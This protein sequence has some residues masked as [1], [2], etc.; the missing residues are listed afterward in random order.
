MEDKVY[1]NG[2]L[3]NF[4]TMKTVGSITIDGNVYTLCVSRQNSYFIRFAGNVNGATEMDYVSARKWADENL[5]K[6]EYNA[7]FG[8]G[9]DNEWR[10]IG[11]ISGKNLE[12]L[13]RIRGNSDTS[14]E[15]TVKNAVQFLLD[16][17]D[18]FA[19]CK[20]IL[21]GGDGE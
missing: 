8:D 20:K 9:S 12:F 15:T 21:Q 11:H 10:R 13:E 14:Y 17:N 6:A 19:Y 7:E 1:I 4:A 3:V 18:K 16:N 2:K 5:P